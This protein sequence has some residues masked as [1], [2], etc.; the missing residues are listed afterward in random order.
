MP[1]GVRQ[2][3]EHWIWN[4]FAYTAHEWFGQWNY[5]STLSSCNFVSAFWR[6]QRSHVGP[7]IMFWILRQLK[8]IYFVKSPDFKTDLHFWKIF[9]GPNETHIGPQA[10]GFQLL[11]LTIQVWL[12]WLT[13]IALGLSELCWVWCSAGGDQTFKMHFNVMMFLL[14]GLWT[15]QEK[16]YQARS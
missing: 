1:T 13:S 9:Y 11:S 8:S 14:G 15:P 2:V 12:M 3:K 5:Q 4:A 6:D 16:R 7:E 10:T